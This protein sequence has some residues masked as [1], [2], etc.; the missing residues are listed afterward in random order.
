MRVYERRSWGEDKTQ[1]LVPCPELGTHKTTDEFKRSLRKGIPDG[2]HTGTYVCIP[3]S[4]F[5]N[6]VQVSVTTQTVIEFRKK[7][8]ET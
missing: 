8:A 6:E 4:C 2:M 7:N 5:E 3:E 1:V